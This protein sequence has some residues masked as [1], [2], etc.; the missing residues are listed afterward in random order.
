MSQ[1]LFLFLAVPL[2]FAWAG[3]SVIAWAD[4]FEWEVDGTQI[5]SNVA[6][7]MNGSTTA[8]TDPVSFTLIETI[9]VSVCDGS[10]CSMASAQLHKTYLKIEKSVLLPCGSQKYLAREQFRQI[11]RAH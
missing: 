5:E 11:G 1:K 10:L 2:Q 6:L 8:D 9:G 7:E 3:E 4:L